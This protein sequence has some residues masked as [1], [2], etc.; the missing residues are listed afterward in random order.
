MGSNFVT[1]S[2]KIR[3]EVWYKLKKRG[4]RFSEIIR[5]AIEEE[6]NKLEKEEELEEKIE[7]ATKILN[8]IPE[9]EVVAS[10]REDRDER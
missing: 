2:A 10:I 1:I 5:R 4:V 6:L 8:K 7:K 3:K 9:E